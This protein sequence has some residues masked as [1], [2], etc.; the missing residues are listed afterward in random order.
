[1]REKGADGEHPPLT[2]E[3]K[4]ERRDALWPTVRELA[5][6][7]DLIDRV[8]Q[9]VQ[10]MGVVNEPQ[11]IT[12]VYIAGT[13]RVLEQPINPVLKGAS[14]SGKNFTMT[15][16]LKLIGPDFVTYLTSS[17]ALSLVYD[18][19]PLSHTILVVFEGTQLQADDHSMFA[20]LLRT[21]ISEGRIVHQT[22]VEDRSSPTGRRVVQIVREGPISLMIAT[23]GELHEENETRMLSWGIS[24]S[25]EQTRAVIHSLASS[26]AGLADAPTDLALWH[27][28][29]RW[30]ALG[31]NEAVVPFAMQIA[32]KTAFSMVRFRRD[33]G[34]LISLISASAFCTRRK[35]R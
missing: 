26:A 30:I 21:L 25:P 35:G 5:E 16:T 18:D 7:P 6:S 13:S 14:G 15:H 11:V 1:V 9:Q 2:A 33:F 31:P 29:Q 23:T 10:S 22:S 12:L 19:R 3:Q 32:A 24:E 28:F 27:D 20:M 4:K 8:V 17:S 34:A